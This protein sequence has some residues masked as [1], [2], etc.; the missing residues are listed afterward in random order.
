MGTVMDKAGRRILSYSDDVHKLAIM[1]AHACDDIPVQDSMKLQNLM[2]MLSSTYEKEDEMGFRPG[3]DGPYSD[4]VE[5]EVRRLCDR[6]ILSIEDGETQ[7][8]AAGRAIAERLAEK[9]P[10]V[11]GRIGR[12]KEMFNDMDADEILT[13]VC[14]SHPSKVPRSLVDRLEP[15]VEKHVLSML[16]KEKI[17]SGKAADLL[18]ERVKYVIDLAYK[19]GIYVLEY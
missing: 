1:L 12:Y 8:T 3:T 19:N 18:G 2:F 15:D 9:E 13:Y 10:D 6:G 5:K 16:R 11:F 17:S 7:L 14:R 4:I